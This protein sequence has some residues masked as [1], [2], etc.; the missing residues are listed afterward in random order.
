[1]LLSRA[2][3]VAQ[4]LTLAGRDDEATLIANQ[5]LQNWLNAV[6]ASWSWPILRREASVSLSTQTK[7]VG[8][9]QGGVS[10]YVLR[11]IDELWWYADGGASYGRIK[12]RDHNAPAIEKFQPTDIVGAPQTYRVTK[13]GFGVARL[14]FDPAPDRTYTLYMA[15]QSLGT[16]LSQD[17]SVPWYENDETLIQAVAFKALEY[18]DGKDAATTQAAQL[19]LA[20]LLNA[21]KFRYGTA[22][23]Q[24]DVVYKDPK[25]F[26]KSRK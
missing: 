6:A 13:P 21:D 4:G 20:G 23:G 15:Y 5:W 9:G 12:L 25:V 1:M 26:P 19:Q 3:I 7:D 14:S 17:S 16:Q 2:Q 11:I 24:N 18:F 8:A 10:D 22:A